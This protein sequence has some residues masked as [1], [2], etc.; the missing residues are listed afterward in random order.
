METAPYPRWLAIHFFRLP[1]E[2]LSLPAPAAAIAQQRI[3]AAD[4]LAAQA[5][6]RPG[7]RLADALALTPALRP[8][9]RQPAREQ[10]LLESLACWGGNFTPHVSLAPPDRLLLEIGGC[11][12]LFG[13]L[14]ALLTDIRRSAEAQGLSLRFGLA[15][16]PLA[17]CWLSH[18]DS[19]TDDWRAA[20][21]ALPVAV[22]GLNAAAHTRLK[23]LGLDTLAALYALPGATLGH[24]FGKML[25]LQLARAR[26]EIPDPQRPFVFP[27]HFS[28]Q[29]ELPAKVDQAERL[30]F[31]A[32]RLLLA[33]AGWLA[34]RMAG[35][36]T[37]TLEL[38]HEDIAPTRL[39]LGFATLT[40]D[41]ERILRVAR[42]QLE[43]HQL[44]AP[45]TELRLL[46]DAAQA[47]PGSS[48]ALFG[49]QDASS[50]APVI[51][52]LRARLGEDAV[53]GL[54]AHPDHRPECATRR[55]PWPMQSP[56]APATGRPRPLWLAARPQALRE[57]RGHPTHGGTALRLLTRAERLE[58]GWWDQGEATGDL[59]R[60][61]FVATTAQGAWVWV[62]R[63]PAGWW[64]HGYFG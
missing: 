8:H 59:R 61:Y 46:A 23:A 30:L 1:V 47:L 11:L 21:D 44:R 49:P 36:S 16:T 25:P 2:V 29:L 57:V 7:M 56:P 14:N 28:E 37:C 40:R 9:E 6:I 31:A 42:E 38:A 33:L 55:L 62:F 52:R 41:G 54:A 35:I 10:A 15:P 64:L 3:V 63:D 53:H 17:A 51:E 5:G 18:I 12:R 24:R 26:G 43:R 4:T 39:T 50:I 58:S 48:A 34:A 60:D 27:Q 19:T 20:L 13:G 45:V 22:L 32:R